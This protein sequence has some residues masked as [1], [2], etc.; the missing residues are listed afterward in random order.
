MLTRSSSRSAGFTLIEILVV[1]TIIALLAALLFPVF[2][3]ARGRARQLTC[4]SNLRQL[5]QAFLLYAHDYDERLPDQWSGRTAS[6]LAASSRAT[7]WETY[8][9]PYTKNR[10]I[11]RCPSETLSHPLYL[12][13][14]GITLMASYAVPFNVQGES[15]SAIHAPTGTVLLVENQ[16][17]GNPGDPDW[18][19]GQLGK[20]SFTP[21]PNVVYEQ[22]DFRHGETGNYLFADAHVQTRRGP[23]PSFPGYKTNPAGVA[24][25][26][27]TDPLPQ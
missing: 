6:S 24:V 22:P 11:N 8:L 7:A 12:P 9:Y 25:C 3:K 20:R 13:E 10:A 27:E 18:L 23:N 5:G 15:L 14:Y 21:D 1:I 26:T 2:V 16:Q 4:V 17:N 19:V